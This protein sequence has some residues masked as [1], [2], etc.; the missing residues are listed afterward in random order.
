MKSESELDKSL[1]PFDNKDLSECIVG[2]LDKYS[3]C[4]I[5]SPKS[6]SPPQLRKIIDSY[7]NND[8]FDELCGSN[9]VSLFNLEVRH[10]RFLLQ[11]MNKNFK[12]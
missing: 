8:L 6:P 1:H 7:G 10:K 11:T 4:N 3:L 2:F 9:S 5:K 12:L